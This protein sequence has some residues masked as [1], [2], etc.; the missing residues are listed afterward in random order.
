MNK[1]IFTK[2]SEAFL[3]DKMCI[4]MIDLNHKILTEAPREVIFFKKLMEHYLK[5]TFPYNPENTLTDIEQNEN[6]N[7]LEKELIF[8]FKNHMLETDSNALKIYEELYHAL[9]SYTKEGLLGL[10]KHKDATYWYPKIII[11]KNIGSRDDIES[12]D[13]E[14]IIYRGTSLN[15]YTSKTFAQAWTLNKDIASSFAFTHYIGQPNYINTERVVIESRINKND[16]YFYDKSLAE[17]EVVINPLKLK[18][19]FTEVI[20]KKILT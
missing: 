13:E 11:S 18:K 16:I 19:D 3:R 10:Y 15:E 17:Q 20:E 5:I 8:F 9:R 14:I 12:L 6:Y 4:C 2:T 1:K 7:L